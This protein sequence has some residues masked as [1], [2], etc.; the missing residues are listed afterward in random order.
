MLEGESSDTIPVTSGVTQGSVLGPIL[1]LVYFND[2]PESVISQVRLFTD[3]TA[4]YMTMT[5][6]NKRKHNQYLQADLDTL[7]E[8]S[9][10][11]Y[12]L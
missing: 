11:G 8:W 9:Y 3:D 1:F 2:L 6:K 7:Q 4:F 10:V 5:D 12:E